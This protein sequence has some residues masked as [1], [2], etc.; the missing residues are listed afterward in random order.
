MNA[1]EILAKFDMELC[2]LTRWSYFLRDRNNKKTPIIE[3]KHLFDEKEWEARAVIDIRDCKYVP[4][5][6]GKTKRLT[7]SK[8]KIC[9]AEHLAQ[10]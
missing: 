6:R 2:Q 4:L 3:I 9:L 5:C 1:L 7:I 8:A 10:S